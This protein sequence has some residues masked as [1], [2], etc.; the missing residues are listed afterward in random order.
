MVSKEYLSNIFTYFCS[1]ENIFTGLRSFLA[2]NLYCG[3]SKN[4]DDSLLMCL[5]ETGGEEALTQEIKGK[6][7]VILK[8]LSQEHI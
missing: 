5:E 2:N 3:F 8:T 1:L 4:M 6:L 7:E